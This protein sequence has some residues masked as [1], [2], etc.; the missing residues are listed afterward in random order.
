MQMGGAVTYRSTENEGVA[1]RRQRANS[2][3]TL[4]RPS[5]F[6]GAA[7][8]QANQSD[9]SS[10]RS[11]RSNS[12]F[13]GNRRP[14]WINA[15]DVEYHPDTEQG[16][17]DYFHDSPEHP[18]LS[19]LEDPKRAPADPESVDIF[20]RRPSAELRSLATMA[21]RG[22]SVSVY[23]DAQSTRD[24]QSIRPSVSRP[25]DAAS[26]SEKVRD[27][28]DESIEKKDVVSPE[29]KPETAEGEDIKIVQWDG[30]D[31]KEHP[32]K[33]SLLY[34]WYITSYIGIFTLSSSF[35]SSCPSAILEDLSKHYGVSAEVSRVAVFVF[36]GG[37][38]L[39]PLIWSSLT[40]NFGFKPVFIVAAV[41]LTVFNFACGGAPN[42]GALIIFRFLAG[43]CGSC[44]LTNG[45][46]VIPSIFG[47]D[48]LGVGMAIFA[49]APMAGPCLG[50]II[51][52]W[53]EVSGTHWQWVF[54]ACGIFSGCCV[55]LTVLTYTETYPGICLSKKAR[56][57]RNTTGD[58]RYKAEFE[59]RKF[60]IKDLMTRQIILPVMLLL[61]EPMLVSSTL[62]L[63]FVYG[64]LYLLFEAFP[65]VFGEL[66]KLN[67]LQ[68]GLCFLGFFVGCT[69]GT[70]YQIFGEN[71]RYQK[72]MARS[73]TG[74]LPPE[75]RLFLCMISAPILV[76]SLFWFAWTS[77]SFVS[78]WSPLV[79]T[80]LFGVGVYF[81]FLSLMAFLADAYRSLAASSIAANTIM[82]SAFGVGFPLFA[83]Q[84]YMN[85]TPKW[86]STILAFI[87]VAMFPIPFLLFKYGGWLRSKAK[88]AT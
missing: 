61:F 84:M 19:V 51:G 73:E 40:E 32:L 3:S 15:L 60:S 31:D 14:S 6:G 28:S 2:Q 66:H 46:A 44:P 58:E 37:Y 33:W 23:H 68:T 47:L 85:A 80:A 13:S 78:F 29:A 9:G 67:P 21:D 74:R 16:E 50:P 88:F 8:A 24:G 87:A 22:D 39:G 57:L 38:C 25:S 5:W 64:T 35:A 53:I 77:Y 76:I 75:Q 55:A 81:N 52:G 27:E 26:V 18:S 34:R 43:T 4:R 11:Q 82:R 41:G 63:S 20:R 59:L 12:I 71:K 30:V 86:A 45:G 36:L 7:A 56:R 48:L 1:P 83:S 69:V 54:W 10:I 65:I 17:H 42:I 79:A 49:L 62:F 72:E 70:L